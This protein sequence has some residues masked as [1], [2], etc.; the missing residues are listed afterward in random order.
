[1]GIRVFD[2]ETSKCILLNQAAADIASGKMEIMQEQ[3]FRELE[4]WRTSGLLE[5]AE[6]VLADGCARMVETDMH[7]SFGR[8]VRVMYSLS[9]LVIKDKPHL[10]VI[11]RDVTEEKLIA[12]EN[13]KIETQMLHVQK[14]E[15]LGV[16]AGGIAHD[17]NN[18]LTAIL[19]NAE[20]ALRQIFPDSG[21]HA[22]LRNI[23]ISARRAADLARQ[24]LAYSG[25]GFFV[26]EQLDVNAIITEMS[27]MLD[28]SISKKATMHLNLA[29]DLPSVRVDTT[30]IRQVIMNLVINASEAIG[31]QSGDITITT[32]M[33]K[34]D[35]AFL[36]ELWLNDKLE[37]GPYVYCEVAD[38]G[39]GMDRDTID[40]IFDP[41]FTTKFTGRGLG[42]AAVLGIVR[43]HKGTIKVCSEQGKGS[44]FKV[45]L[46]AMS[47]CPANTLREP[48]LDK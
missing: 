43:G 22:H 46:P 11:G 23:E 33:Q 39:C 8:H 13:R 37:G 44:N 30:Q 31:D 45:F 26:I 10:L 28:V 12:D 41:F 47:E 17:F 24:M 21:A 48:E 6:S 19:G 5:V 29:P 14:L 38:T 32:G 25:K 2:G 27:R 42:M 34:C 15:S 3:H 18:I 36:S 40:K 35:E 20:L 7:T 9:K 4:S 16:M 1:M